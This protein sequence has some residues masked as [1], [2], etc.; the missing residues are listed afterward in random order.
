MT[1]TGFLCSRVL[2]PMKLALELQC[3]FV[4]PFFSVYEFFNVFILIEGSL[5]YTIMLVS[6]MHQHESAIGRHM[7]PAS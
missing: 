6:A 2:L 4:F 3:T 5:L 1:T 7:S